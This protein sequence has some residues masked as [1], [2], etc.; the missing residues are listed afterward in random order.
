MYEGTEEKQKSEKRVSDTT[1]EAGTKY[2]RSW[3]V[4][5]NENLNH[6]HE[7]PSICLVLRLC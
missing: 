4:D 2:A 7:S 1:V 5:S 6:I 3:L